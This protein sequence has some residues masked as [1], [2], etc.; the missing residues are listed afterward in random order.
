MESEGAYFNL[1][2]KVWEGFI[3]AGI[4][5]WE[6]NHAFLCIAAARNDVSSLKKILKMQKEIISTNSM[7]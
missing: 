5:P 3:R 1:P 6:V 7:N 2:T 4:D